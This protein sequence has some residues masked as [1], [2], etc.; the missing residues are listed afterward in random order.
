MYK[1]TYSVLL[2]YI[3]L[4]L[5]PTLFILFE[6]ANISS[7]LLLEIKVIE[8]VPNCFITFFHG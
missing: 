2:I 7:K 5:T 8:K 6:R 4:N 3:V 1:C